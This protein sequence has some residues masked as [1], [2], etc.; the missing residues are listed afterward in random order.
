ME[1][2]TVRQIDQLFTNIAEKYITVREELR[3]KY[4][5]AGK[6]FSLSMKSA[7]VQTSGK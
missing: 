2:A 6:T 3:A 7:S 1:P 4:R 5:D